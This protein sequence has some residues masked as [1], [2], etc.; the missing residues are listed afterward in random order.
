MDKL[1]PTRV[2]VVDAIATLENV[3]EA[4]MPAQAPGSTRSDVRQGADQLRAAVEQL[5]QHAEAVESALERLDQNG[6]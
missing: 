3:I 4:L 1:D 5:I 6:G 2:I